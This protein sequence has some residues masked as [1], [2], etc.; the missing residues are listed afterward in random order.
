MPVNKFLIFVCS[1]WICLF[2]FFPSHHIPYFEIP[3]TGN[4][5]HAQEH[6]EDCPPELCEEGGEEE[7]EEEEEDCPPEMCGDEEEEEDIG[8]DEEEDEA[9][10]ETPRI[11]VDRTLYSRLTGAMRN[12]MY[13]H[14]SEDE[15]IETV[16][17]WILDGKKRMLFFKK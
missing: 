12:S 15:E 9:V 1:G 7:T 5:L 13:Q 14:V 4:P 2:V 17:K 11:P 10:G 16:E 8:I 3:F 6:E